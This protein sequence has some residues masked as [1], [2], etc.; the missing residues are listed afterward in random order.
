[1]QHP[2]VVERR[3]H[4]GLELDPE[5]EARVAGELVEAAERAMDRS[6]ARGALERPGAL[7][8]A[9]GQADSTSPRLK[10]PARARPPC[11]GIPRPGR[12]CSA[13]GSPRMVR[14]GGGSAPCGRRFRWR[15]G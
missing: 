12:P 14:A 10:L 9:A 3:H 2:A 4:A 7:R 5:L 8:T 11:R 6:E 1:M 13:T 15:A